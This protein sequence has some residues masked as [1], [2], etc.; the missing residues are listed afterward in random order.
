LD[1]LLQLCQRGFFARFRKRDICTLHRDLPLLLG[2]GKP[3]R[4]GQGWIYR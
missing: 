3:L 2:G 1:E 4:C